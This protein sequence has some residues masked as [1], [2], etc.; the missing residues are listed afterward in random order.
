MQQKLKQQMEGEAKAAAASSSG[1]PP[2]ESMP[3]PPPKVARKGKK[4]K[5]GK[6]ESEPEPATSTSTSGTESAVNAADTRSLKRLRHVET[7]DGDVDVRP[8]AKA[9][10]KP[11]AKASSKS[12]TSALTPPDFEVTWE[13]HHLVMKHF[14]INEEE[15]TAS[16]LAVIGPDERYKKFW[17]KFDTKT[18][19]KHGVEGILEHEENEENAEMEAESN[20]GEEFLG[21]G[22]GPRKDDPDGPDEEDVETSSTTSSHPRGPPPPPAA[23]A[24]PVAKGQPLIDTLETQPMEVPEPVIQ[25][26]AGKPDAAEEARMELEKKLKTAPTPAKAL[27]KKV[28][29]CKKCEIYFQNTGSRKCVK[30]QCP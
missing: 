5:Q 26:V 11:V 22:P 12:K 19:E 1:P 28:L 18:A 9:K 2:D 20:D 29:S 16:L 25:A 17:G 30:K 21:G 27:E 8:K 14:G 24:E 13:N 10:A 23:V 6:R 4:E 3:P 15:A 7:E